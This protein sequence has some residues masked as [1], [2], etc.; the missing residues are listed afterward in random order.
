M[1]SYSFSGDSEPLRDM[2]SR[3]EFAAGM[4]LLRG[5]SLQSTRLQ[6]AILRR[7]QRPIIESLD[8]LRDMDRELEQ[9]VQAVGPQASPPELEALTDM[10]AR[11]KVALD[12]ET[13]ALM[14][15][16]TGQALKGAKKEALDFEDEPSA[17]EEDGLEEDLYAEEPPRRLGAWIAGSLLVLAAGG[18]A[19]WYYYPDLLIG[20]IGF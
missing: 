14:S 13:M 15:G 17:V 10:I 2:I 8:L 3:S 4:N 19:A 7:E 16:V 9:F 20:R 6:V 12:A 18:A 5:V 11:Q 1:L